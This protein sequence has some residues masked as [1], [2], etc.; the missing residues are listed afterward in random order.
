M[1]D[2]LPPEM[3]FHTL[4]L[5]LL[6]AMGDRLEA[7][8]STM[9]AQVFCV[10]RS[11]FYCR[12]VCRQWRHII[13]HHPLWNRVCALNYFSCM[14]EIEKTPFY[15]HVGSEKATRSE[16]FYQLKETYELDFLRRPLS[17]FAFQDFVQ[18]SI[19]KDVIVSYKKVKYKSFFTMKPQHYPHV[20]LGLSQ[21]DRPRTELSPAMPSASSRHGLRAELHG[22]ETSQVPVKRELFQLHNLCLLNNKKV[23]CDNQSNH[24]LYI[25]EVIQS[26]LNGLPLSEM[27]RLNSSPVFSILG[28]SGTLSKVNCS[29]EHS[30]LLLTNFLCARQHYGMYVGLMAYLHSTKEGKTLIDDYRHPSD[31]ISVSDGDF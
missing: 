5:C 21:D 7:G 6:G 27:R 22:E 16:R 3:I 24:I 25:S 13:D 23:S 31:D 29:A 20:N 19:L 14:F 10:P 18:L 17:P 12:L 8:M 15:K 4:G 9:N 30:V 1:M 26:I 2:F 11:I 28:I